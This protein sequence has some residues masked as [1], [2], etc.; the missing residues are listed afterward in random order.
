MTSNSVRAPFSNILLADQI[1]PPKT[2]PCLK[3]WKKQ[4][5][6]EGITHKLPA[7][8]VVLAETPSAREYRFPRLKWTDS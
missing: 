2:R 4:V 8:F 5:T 1:A 6:I 7:P 3:P